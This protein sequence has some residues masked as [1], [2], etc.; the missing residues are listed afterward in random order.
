MS[1]LSEDV[2][3]V[4][5]VRLD[6][7]P[8]IERCPGYWVRRSD[9]T[10]DGLVDKVIR[11]TRVLRVLYDEDDDGIDISEVPY[12]EPNLEWYKDAEAESITNEKQAVDVLV[13]KDIQ[14]KA[15]TK[16]QAISRGRYTYL[17]TTCAVLTCSAICI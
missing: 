2:D 14:E 3:D 12:D 16:I 1:E 8:P 9:D 7:P 4:Q 6:K 15:A 17:C 13:E 10:R 5:L 11:N